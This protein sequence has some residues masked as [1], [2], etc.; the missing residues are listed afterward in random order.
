MRIHNPENHLFVSGDWDCMP[1]GKDE[2][3]YFVEV[4]EEDHMTKAI[5]RERNEFSRGSKI[6]VNGMPYTV[7]NV[8]VTRMRIGE[9]KGGWQMFAIIMVGFVALNFVLYGGLAWA[10]G[11]LG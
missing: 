1:C 6:T 5:R 4:N 8:R 3:R 11:W 9:W 10:M 2:R 7:K